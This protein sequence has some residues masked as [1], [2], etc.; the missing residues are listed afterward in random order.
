MRPYT[1]LLL[2]ADKGTEFLPERPPANNPLTSR[3]YNPP[4][5][6]PISS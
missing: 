1:L 4:A 2:F 6:P 5:V 3:P